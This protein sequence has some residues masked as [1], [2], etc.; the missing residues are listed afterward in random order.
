MRV[1]SGTAT[2]PTVRISLSSPGTIRSM[3]KIP[4]SLEPC[5][6]ATV[7]SLLLKQGRFTSLFSRCRRYDHPCSTYKRLTLLIPRLLFRSP[8]TLLNPPSTGMPSN[9]SATA[10]SSRASSASASS[11]LQTHRARAPGTQKKQYLPRASVP[12]SSLTAWATR[13][14]WT[15]MTCRARASLLLI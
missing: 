6:S 4:Q 13:W 10:P 11:N 14:A 5:L 3:L 15:Y 1:A 12:L 8:S 2:L 9:S 7:A